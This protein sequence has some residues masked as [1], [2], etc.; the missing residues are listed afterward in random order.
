MHA[1]GASVMQVAAGRPCARVLRR[2]A[3][4]YIVPTT[5]NCVNLSAMSCVQFLPSE[6]S[7]VLQCPN[8][9]YVHPPTNPR[10]AQKHNALFR[11]DNLFF[12]FH[13]KKA[14]KRRKESVA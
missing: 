3:D 13:Q 4:V 8:H 14:K 1:R 6:K 7:S 10:P 11:P 2:P 5:R 9:D 12:F